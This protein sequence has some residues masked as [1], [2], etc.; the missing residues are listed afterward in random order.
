MRN[1]IYLKYIMSFPVKYFKSTK[2]LIRKSF[3]KGLK[4]SLPATIVEDTEL[5]SKFSVTYQISEPAAY[6]VTV[7]EQPGFK[8]KDET[9]KYL[10]GIFDF[11]GGTTDFNFGVWRGANDDEYDK[12]NCDYVLECFG[13]DSDVHMGGE[14]ILEMLAYQVFKNNKNMAAEK[15]IAYALPVDQ[16]SFIGGEHLIN[17]SQSANR[18]LTLLK[19]ALR[20]LWEQHDNWE[21]KY[22][23]QKYVT[24]EEAEYVTLENADKL[25]QWEETDELEQWEETDELEQKE[26]FIEIQMYDFNGKPVP[27]C[28]FSIDTKQLLEL[29]KQRIQKGT[30]AFFKCIESNYQYIPNAKTSVAYGLVKS[31]PIFASFLRLTWRF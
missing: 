19:E 24:L 23:K 18:N 22:C 3:E 20:P 16:T 4:K 5:M 30:D 25:E 9:E 1:G 15:K 27:N 11:G 29:I 7:L 31:R 2:E 14:N 8:P 28:R 13:A 6:A 17:N 26:E 21:A 12:F 10:Y